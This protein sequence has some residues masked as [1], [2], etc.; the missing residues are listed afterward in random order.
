MTDTAPDTSIYDRTSIKL[1]KFKGWSSKSVYDYDE[2]IVDYESLE[3]LNRTINQARKA[4]FKTTESIG[5]YE[6]K[7]NTAKI[8]YDRAYR[9]EF[10]SSTA[11]TESEKRMRAAL[12]CEDLENEWL[13]HQQVREEL[14]RYSAT[15]RLELQTLQGLGHNY[16]QQMKL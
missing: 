2:E 7:E 8:N 9:R 10:L 6:R 15:L 4:L 1:P 16:R 12:N 13:M 5:S 3:A 14:V 11:K